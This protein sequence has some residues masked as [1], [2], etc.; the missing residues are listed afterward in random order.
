MFKFKLILGAAILLFGSAANAGLIASLQAHISRS[1]VNSPPKV[2]LVEAFEITENPGTEINITNII[3]SIEEDLGKID[4][5]NTV[6]PSAGSSVADSQVTLPDI[7]ILA[8][9][10]PV[11]LDLGLSA[12]NTHVEELLVPVSDDAQPV[13]A[14]AAL[15]LFGIGLIGLVGCRRQGKDT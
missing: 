8:S 2:T 9:I 15:W 10:E 7:G 6:A 13:P 1:T 3:D 4:G 14:P 12:T 11:A 5:A